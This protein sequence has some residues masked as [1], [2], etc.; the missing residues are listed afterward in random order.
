MAL[1]H[2]LGE[3]EIGDVVT[4]RGGKRLLNHKD[5]LEK[6]RIGLQKVLIDSNNPEEYLQLFD[7][8]EENTTD[9]AKLVKQLDRL[10][11]AIQAY[12]YE[13][14]HTFSLEEFFLTTDAEVTDQRL[15]LILKDIEKLR[16]K[17]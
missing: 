9:E 2:D 12:E 8:Y 11:M 6:E 16:N 4:V 10:E 1:I 5:K 7:E 15:R 13:T 3:A 14:A 17:E